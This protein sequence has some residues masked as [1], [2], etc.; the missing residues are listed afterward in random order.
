MRIEKKRLFIAVDISKAV[1]EE[2]KK[3]VYKKVDLGR[4]SWVNPENYH[5]TLKFLGDVPVSEIDA[6]AGIMEEAAANKGE[7]TLACTQLGLFPNL[8]RPR[9]L[10]VG[11]EDYSGV[12]GKIVSE[13]EDSL[14]SR[15]KIK[16]ERRPFTPHMT[17]A[18]IKGNVDHIRLSKFVKKGI[19]LQ[20]S[21]FT[22]SKI[23]LYSSELKQSGAVHTILKSASLK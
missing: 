13:L 16:K 14:Q 12:L 18:R 1:C 9:V 2:L 10:W 7:L 22:V 6:I 5:I 11:F 17:V 8:A 4:A 20:E 21:S 23:N 15:L 3:E 19:D